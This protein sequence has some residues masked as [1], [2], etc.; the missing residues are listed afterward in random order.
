[1]SGLTWH[2][3]HQHVKRGS[4]YQVVG[5]ASLQTSTG[6]L[7]D[8]ALMVVYRASDGRFWVRLKDEFDGRFVALQEQSR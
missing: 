7:S 2:P 8:G 1:M 5:E 6:G 3:T 4:R